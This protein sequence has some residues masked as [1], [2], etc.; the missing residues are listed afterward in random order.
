M[1]IYRVKQPELFSMNINVNVT[2][3]DTLY[4]CFSDHWCVTVI[5]VDFMTLKYL[6][7]MLSNVMFNPSRC[8]STIF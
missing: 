1:K 8:V 2:A 7:K 3:Y 4:L 5:C 6:D